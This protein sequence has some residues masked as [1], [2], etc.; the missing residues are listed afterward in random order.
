MA[1][2]QQ[3]TKA[4]DDREESATLSAI[5][6]LKDPSLPGEVR[7]YYTPGFEKRAKAMQDFLG[8]QRAFYRN[9]LGS[10]ADLTMA[11]LD[12]QQWGQLNI[13]DPYGI[14]T[15]PDDPPYVALMPANWNEA[16][17]GMLP[18][19]KEANPLLVQ[20]VRSAGADW[21]QTLYR[22]FDTMIGHEYGHAVTT[23]YG[24]NTPTRWFNEFLA[25]YFLVA[26]VR[27]K[28][29]QLAF[30]MHVFFSVGLGYPHPYTSLSDFE[31][32][33]PI[34]DKLPANYS[35]YQSMFEK[36]AEEVYAQQG[37]GFLKEVK[38]AFPPGGKAAAMSNEEVLKRLDKIC[39]GFTEWAHSFDLAGHPK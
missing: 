31:T 19:E 7:T 33:Y 36:R 35:W 30:P 39:P 21:Q 6:A 16:H 32:H 26:Y 1:R 18:D 20:Q 22:G 8:G 3:V 37:V 10:Q 28:Q 34:S 27:Q 2:A 12:A 23:A 4:S 11:V 17:L 9:E 13:R 24:I 25:D 29:P 38:T 14:P 5:L 15:I